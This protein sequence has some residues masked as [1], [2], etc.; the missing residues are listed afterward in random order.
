ML[1]SPLGFSGMGYG[2]SYSSPYGYGGTMGGYGGYGS[3]GGPGYGY[4]Y[5]GYGQPMGP[6]GTQPPVSPAMR[7]METTQMISQAFARTAAILDQNLFA[8]RGSYA[9]L[10]EL[11]Q[12]LSP[13]ANFGPFKWLFALVRFVLRNFAVLFGLTT[14]HRHA[15]R[16][17]PPADDK[18]AISPADFDAFRSVLRG[19]RGSRLMAGLVLAAVVALPYLIA[20]LLRRMQPPQWLAAF[21][22]E[23]A[24][25]EPAVGAA[26]APVP[27]GAPPAGSRIRALYD[28]AACSPT[29]LSF[30]AGDVLVVDGVQGGDGWWGA[31]SEQ[32]GL[33]GLVPSNFVEV[34]GGPLARK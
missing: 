5:G 15:T 24:T 32:S 14:L 2:N 33:R 1:S 10:Q 34:V 17:A 4:G 25:S 13:A 9:S 6:P 31:V 3:Y 7:V 28:Y 20:K 8:L 27:A 22:S 30:K 12:L 23:W 29:D 21:E 19:P 11:F 16:P 18:Q 26:S